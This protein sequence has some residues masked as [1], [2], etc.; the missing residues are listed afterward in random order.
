MD[1]NNENI[2]TEYYD[3]Y[4]I[5][6]REYIMLL[7][8]NKWFIAG[9]VAAALIITFFYSFFL[10]GPV[11]EAK[12]TLLILP[13]KYKTSLEVSTLPIETYKNLAT[14]DTIKQSIID[15]LD[16]KNEKNEK[17]TTAQ[18]ERMMHIEVIIGGASDNSQEN[19]PLIVLTVKGKNPELITK[20]ANL[21]AEKFISDSKQIRIGEIQEVSEVIQ[22]QFS[23]TEI[24]LKNLKDELLQ[25]K[26]EHRLRIANSELNSKQN[27]LDNLN[28]RIVDLK[29]ELGS[30]KAVYTN[31]QKQI[32][33]LQKEGYW[34]GDLNLD[35]DKNNEL[36]IA[37]NNYLK[38]ENKLLDF[39]KNNNLEL[40]KQ[41]IELKQNRIQRY[42]E[43]ISNLNNSLQKLKEENK[44][45]KNILD[46]EPEKWNLNKSLSNDAFWENILNKEKIE[47][48]KDL[49]LSNEIINPVFQ[50][51]KVRYSDN[52]VTLET[53]P[54][55]IEYYRS[56][57]NNEVM[58]LNRYNARY[59][60]LSIKKDHLASDLDKYK[61]IYLNHANKY[62]ELLAAEMN[63]KLE[64]ESL[65]AQL[66]F[67][68]DSRNNLKV[69]IK[70]LQNNIWKAENIQDRLQQE[71]DNVKNTYSMLAK[72]VE[73]A[74]IAEA[75]RT[76][77]VKFFAKA[78]EPT[79]PVENNLKLNLAIA[80]V[81]ALMLGVFIVF[82]KE[83]MK[84]E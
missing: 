70:T 18:L 57:L 33:N 65:S 67:Y 17:L 61:K 36:Q 32:N 59:K 79:E 74:R 77:D 80:G 10:A 42:K 28:N 8:D 14:T 68:Q 40:M 83:F 45:I 24:K 16:L 23:E 7:W 6:L 2:R 66:D 78:V 76:S 25:F 22:N 4:E 38:T 37:K 51:L 69:E 50:R 15:E 9:L 41:E 60:E 3:E 19:A 44:N 73:E 30:Q 39:N 55:E 75:Q 5:D 81:L 72:R 13:P 47:I 1:E 46:K 21:W 52:K 27:K 26:K 11:Y 62:K 31:L 29:S 34:S 48:L 43:M 63:T 58:E 71:I 56:E 64:V 12:S 53:L 49:Q 54:Q 84:E 82:F 20:M 35:T